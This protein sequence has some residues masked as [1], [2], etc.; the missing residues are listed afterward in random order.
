M[1]DMAL[2]FPHPCLHI[3]GEIVGRPQNPR[4]PTEFYGSSRMP[5]IKC[6]KKT[7]THVKSTQS[8][9]NRI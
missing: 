6:P 8:K 3:L 1:K 7:M 5:A 4:H 9:W 2:K